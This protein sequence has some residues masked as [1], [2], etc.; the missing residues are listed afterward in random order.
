MCGVDFKDHLFD[1]YFIPNSYGNKREDVIPESLFSK[2]DKSIDI[3]SADLKFE[4]QLL[5]NEFLL[6]WLYLHEQSHLFQYHSIVE[7]EYFNS[8]S[9]AEFLNIHEYSVESSNKLSEEEAWV[10]H[11]FEL[12]A[13]HE[14]LYL[15][16]QYIMKKTMDMY[17]KEEISL[18]LFWVFIC[19]I[20][21]VFE[22]FYGI[23][24][25]NHNGIAKGTHPNPDIRL[26]LMI[27]H[28]INFLKNKY[29]IKHYEKGKTLDDYRSVL[30]HALKTIQIFFKVTYRVQIKICTK[31]D[32]DPLVWLNSSF[33]APSGVLSA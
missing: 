26:K 29:V 13:D 6:T 27:E 7:N 33:P 9:N 22:K 19:C 1:E 20:G 3:K 8:S 24:R 23:D 15:S 17:G 11:A 12:S 14:A 4:I 21:Y 5:F 25:D 2:F 31:A 30:N 18:D 10:S 32:T 28:I 16:M